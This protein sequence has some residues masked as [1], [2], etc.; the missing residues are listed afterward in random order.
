MGMRDPLG[1]G[2]AYLKTDNSR[3]MTGLDGFRSP[4][5]EGPQTRYMYSPLHREAAVCC[6]PSAGRLLPTYARYQWLLGEAA[7]RPQVLALL[8][9]ASVLRTGVGGVPVT[10]TQETDYPATT[11]IRFTMEAAEPVAFSLAIR[12][13]AWARGVQVAG[14]AGERV[15]ASP[16]LLRVHGP[17]SGTTTVEVRFWAAPEVRT[18]TTG[19]RLVAHGPLLF[20]LPITG[21]R[22]TIRTHAVDGIDACFEDVHVRPH[23]PPPDLRLPAGAHPCPAPVPP[24][25][26]ASRA[27]HAWQRRALTVDLVDAGGHRREHV[28]VPMGATVLRIVAFPPE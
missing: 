17:W 19:E 26:E 12:R 7:G 10:I 25:A 9:G 3:S 20:A 18:A 23:V 22:T 24:R 21:D 14:V 27:P 4:P 16:S 13:P 1:T 2:V 15:H 28:L 5:P 6:V 8:F 11:T